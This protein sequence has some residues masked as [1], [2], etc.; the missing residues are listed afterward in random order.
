MKFPA[1]PV[2]FSI[3]YFGKQTL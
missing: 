2:T 3:Y 1:L